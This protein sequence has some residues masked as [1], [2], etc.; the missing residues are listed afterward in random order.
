M[1]KAL[2]VLMLVPLVTFGGDT[3][4]KRLWSF[5][6]ETDTLRVTYGPVIIGTPAQKDTL[7]TLADVRSNGGF[8]PGTGDIEAVTV[9]A[10][11]T[12]GN[13]SGTAN[14]GFDSV[15]AFA[16]MKGD[17]AN[18]VPTD[19]LSGTATYIPMFSSSHGMS[20]S[21]LRQSDATKQIWFR[22]GKF[23]ISMVSD[24]PAYLSWGDDSL[25]TV[26][27]APL[28]GYGLLAQPRF[29]AQF[30]RTVYGA[31]FRNLILRTGVPKLNSVGIYISDMYDYTNAT[32]NSYGLVVGPI[33]EGTSLNVAF[34]T[35]AGRVILRDTTWVANNYLYFGTEGTATNRALGENDTTWVARKD[36]VQGQG[37]GKYGPSDTTTF[38]SFIKA[39]AAAKLVPADTN[40]IHS[41][42]LARV[43]TTRYKADSTAVRDS[44]AL[45]MR[46]RDFA[47]SIAAHPSGM[48]TTS[49]AFLAYYH[50]HSFGISSLTGDDAY[51]VTADSLGHGKN[52]YNVKRPPFNAK[53]DGSTDDCVAIQKAIDSA[54]VN[55]GLVFFPPGTYILQTITPGNGYLNNRMLT[56]KSNVSLMG[57]GNASVLKMADNVLSHT[58]DA[59]NANFFQGDS[60]ENVTISDLM[61]DGNAVHNLTPNGKERNAMFVRIEGGKNV[62]IRN[63]YG[64]NSA[65]RNMIVFGYVANS[66][67][68]GN[69]S[70]VNSVFKNGGRYT[71]TGTP[72]TYNTDF[73]FLY[74]EWPET[75]IEGNLIEQENVDSALASWTGGME[76]HAS[77]TIVINNTFI[78]CYPGI[79]ACDL[80]GRSS[81]GID[82]SHNTFDRCKMWVDVD[83]TDTNGIA[84]LTISHNHG[85]V[86]APSGASEFSAISFD[87]ANFATD[88]DAA[89][90]NA[91]KAH[92]V[93]IDNNIIT[94][95]LPMGSLVLTD[96]ISATSLWDSRIHDNIITGLT[97]NGIQLIGSPWGVVNVMV[98][99]NQI[100]DC[101][102]GYDDDIEA[103]NSGL[104]VG[105]SGHTTTPGTDYFADNVIFKGNEIG[106]DSTTGSYNHIY[107]GVMTYHLDSTT[108]AVKNIWFERNRFR[109]ITKEFYNYSSNTPRPLELLNSTAHW[110]AQDGE[111]AD[112]PFYTNRA[113]A[114]AAGL[115]I[116]DKFRSGTD[117]TVVSLVDK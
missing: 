103:R 97:A 46:K 35:H 89:H 100:T 107:C 113:A 4:A 90:G 54:A 80:V 92:N 8:T 77:N 26:D 21:L 102:K 71:G 48:D 56:L 81:V 99:D 64:R 10:P 40:Y 57:I 11:I 13:T 76:V 72:N 49:A 34:E 110:I 29:G 7:A 85:S 39:V 15:A 60:I 53:G 55:G 38:L 62:H 83:I 98:K 14:I 36:W 59:Y 22:R 31:Y 43:D 24:S 112:L 52:W 19:S 67:G 66:I 1:Y 84:N 45:L 30:T 63:V 75:N 86:Y 32:P 74:S 27:Q 65:G 44:I 33:T 104:Y 16:K 41:Q 79:Y 28:D 109:N 73:S 106:N 9:T 5:A 23:G 78:G 18:R 2:V 6:Q 61:F 68:N 111:R 87:G 93:S 3:K 47:D 50:N 88:W 70:I 96:G 58:S 37:Y 108:T 114:K 105:L 17:I 25:Y 42:I 51:F 94:S 117:S 12:G 115:L 82:I 116:G 69:C 20:N 95:K 101:G 91:G